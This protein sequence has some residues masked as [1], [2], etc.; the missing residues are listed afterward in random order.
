MIVAVVVA[1]V[2][3]LSSLVARCRASSPN[4]SCP[5]GATFPVYWNVP[6]FM[7]HRHNMMF[8]DLSRWGLVQN[9]GDQ[10][11]GER[12]VILYDPGLFPALVPTPA[13]KVERRNGGVPQEG[14]LTLHL[15][16]IRQEVERLVP[17]RFFD[18]I[19]V[20]DFESWRPI[21]RQN[22][23]SLLPYRELSRD[24][25]KKRHPHWKPQDVEKQAKHR[26]EV[27]ARKF[28]E[29][30][31]ELVR[32]I[33]PQGKWGYYAFPFCYN[34]TPKNMAS[35]CPTQV[36]AE[37]DEIQWLFDGSES[38]YPSLYLSSHKMTAQERVQFVVG[39]LAEAVRVAA[40]APRRI[41]VHPYI[42]FKYHDDARY[43]S[44][45]DLFNS[46]ALSKSMGRGGAVIW[47]S[48]KDVNT[49]EKCESLAHYVEQVLGPTVRHVRLM[50]HL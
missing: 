21:F 50:T 20:L 34:Y 26:F 11:R 19:A 30:T 29:E 16:T 17:N 3:A 5:G 9:Q 24:I 1:W 44:Q 6:T 43:L 7:C 37:N 23:G 25:E 49:R 46:L 47:G 13:G 32:Q 12:V 36:M 14:N 48:A 40:R 33:R 4:S 45:V 22:W 41:A 27:A 39:R 31:L 15:T 28:L 35:T 10:F 2:A 8:G 18:G 42:W 38:V